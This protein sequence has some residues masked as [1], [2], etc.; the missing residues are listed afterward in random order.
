[1]NKLQSSTLAWLDSHFA[2]IFDHQNV[3]FGNH[4]T[5]DGSKSRSKAE[6]CTEI[7]AIC[8]VDDSQNYANQCAAAGIS[9]LLFGRYPWNS[10]SVSEALA[11]QTGRVTRVM[12]WHETKIMLRKRILLELNIVKESVP[13]NNSDKVLSVPRP[14]EFFLP[15]VAVIQLCST[16]DKAA[17]FEKIKRLIEKASMAG[18]SL[19]CLPEACL[20]VGET[21]METVLNAEP[22][23]GEF[24]NQM[25][26]L[27]RNFQ[28]WV[29]FCYAYIEQEYSPK[30]YN[31]HVLVDVL[32]TVVKTY[33]KIHL[34]D[35]PMAGLEESA[36][37]VAGGSLSCHSENPFGSIA[38]T[39]CYDLRF[40]QLFAKLCQPVSSGGFGADIILVPSAFTVPTGEAHWEVLLRARA[41]ENQ[42]WVIAAAQCGQHNP[43]RASYG[44]SIVIDPWGKVVCRLDGETEGVSVVSLDVALASSIREK[45]PGESFLCCSPPLRVSRCAHHTNPTTF[46]FFY[47]AINNSSVSCKEPIVLLN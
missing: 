5:N 36:I 11:L 7:G 2:G 25:C 18:A 10:D 27:A 17:N 44:N 34:F 15:K 43:N 37:T 28:V 29:S 16:N 26:S 6:M 20:C 30:I 21:P 42:A 23:D 47:N 14:R 45:M 3:H 40:P 13:A 9:V 38:L 22:L 31:R 8:L 4:Y 33:D 19:V 35:S 39:V 41:I 32:G 12:N 24:F 46:L 1:M